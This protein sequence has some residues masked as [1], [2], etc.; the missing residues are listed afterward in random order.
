MK[1]RYFLVL[2]LAAFLLA[3]CGSSDKVMKCSLTTTDASYT[4]Q[5][6]YEV[7]HD[8]KYISY[9]E[10]KETVTSNDSSILDQMES[11]MKSMYASLGAS[12]GGYDYN[13]NKS[14]NKVES[15]VKTDYTKM[16]L[17]KLVESDSSASIFVEGDKVT[18]S[19]M[20]EVYKQLGVTC[21]D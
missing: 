17:K 15:K 4:L 12:Y 1:K 9:V 13:V 11:Y 3:G 21:Q 14:G 20:K 10:M 6:E 19:G 16:D 18:L 8:G 2:L 5:S 7:H